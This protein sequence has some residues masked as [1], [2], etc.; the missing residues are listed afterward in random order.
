MKEHDLH[1]K[2]L[3]SIDCMKN[4]KESYKKQKDL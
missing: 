2:I 3:D 1:L 4:L